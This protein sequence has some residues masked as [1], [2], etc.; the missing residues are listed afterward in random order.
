MSLSA[1]AE[2]I[3]LFTSLARRRGTGRMAETDVL[4]NR[5]IDLAHAPDFDLCGNQVRPAILEIGGPH[6][7]ELLEPRVMQMLVALHRAK[8]APVSRDDLV[9]ECWG[10]LAISDDAITQC[11]SKLRRSLAEFRGIQV[12]SVP[13]VGYRLVTTSAMAGPNGPAP[14]PG[15]QFRGRS[16]A[17]GM[18][19]A[20]LV[21]TL[22][23]DSRP[24]ATAA[25]SGLSP[26]SAWLAAPPPH[27]ADR[28]H[29]TAVRIFRERTRPGYVEAEK[30]LRRAVAEEPGH[31][32]SWAR[33]AMVVYA[34]WWWAQEDDSNA[35]VRLRS[36]AIGYAR[37]ALS[38]DPNLAEAHQAMGFIIG[39][40]GGLR[41]LERAA[42][43]AP[44]DAEI[45]SQ[46]ADLLE[47]RLELR[48]A[49]AESERALELEPTTP[50]IIETA[51]YFRLRLGYRT[52]AYALLDDLDRLTHRANEVRTD[53]FELM[54]FEGRLADA[55][56]QCS[57]SL[58]LGDEDR[59]WAQAALIQ[60]AVQFGHSGLRARLLE[61]QPKLADVIAFHD[62]SYSV[63]LARRSPNDWWADLFIA[64]L[65]RQLVNAGRNDLL[66]SLYDD[67][68]RDVSEFWN[69][70]GENADFLAPPLIIAMVAAG[71]TGESA[72]LR[73]RLAADIA[74][75]AREGDRSARLPVGRAQLAAIDG[76]A[77]AS[78]HWLDVAVAGGWK[79]QGTKLGFG[80]DRDPVFANVRRA[81]AMQ[82]A[83]RNYQAVMRAEASK[84]AA[85]R[86]LQQQWAQP[87][88]SGRRV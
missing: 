63:R 13:R 67:R 78:A 80:P 15:L 49:Y 73:A 69:D 51:S 64:A 16:I 39:G 87:R 23:F 22:G 43:L 60:M 58:D 7:T 48:R 81:P 36:Q 70:Q 77:A 84:F 40:A 53:R 30:L 71:R 61:L 42:E 3:M 68:Y 52:E 54:F 19:L 75:L 4:R 17:T 37:R 9:A 55:A 57:R 35:R 65:A 11:V 28:L 46:L 79:A 85:L 26:S 47:T 76:D 66:L 14:T 32:P 72:D 12:M 41:W 56:K 24:A 44:D 20:A 50:R 38:L 10:G 62:A 33:L 2:G 29:A 88:P 82:R 59:W 34:P 6:G 5:R 74:K 1:S 25:L 45:H 21:A 8:G 18:V 27:E 86:L 83:V 31:A